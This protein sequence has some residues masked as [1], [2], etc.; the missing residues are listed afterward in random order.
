MHIAGNPSHL[1]A[2]Q[3]ELI[4]LAATLGREKFAPR[5]ATHD[6]DASFPFEIAG[7]RLAPGS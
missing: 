7:A 1:T 3:R 5:A 4:E 6:R 2:Q